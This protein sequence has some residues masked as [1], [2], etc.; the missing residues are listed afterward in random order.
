MAFTRTQY[1][2]IANTL[3][4]AYLKHDD[5]SAHAVALIANEFADLFSAVNPS[6]KRERFLA[7]VAEYSEDGIDKLIFNY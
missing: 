2:V 1:K 6:F 4:T 7:A 3:Q 5:V